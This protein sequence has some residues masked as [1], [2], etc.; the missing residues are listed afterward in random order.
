MNHNTICLD[1]DENNLQHATSV[2]DIYKQWAIFSLHFLVNNSVE[3]FYRCIVLFFFF[4]C[5]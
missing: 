4:F 1:P 2:L 5:F 3:P